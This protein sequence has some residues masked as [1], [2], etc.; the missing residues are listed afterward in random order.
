MAWACIHVVAVCASEDVYIYVPQHC[1]SALLCQD[2]KK[3]NN[4]KQ[5]CH[6]GCY[7]CG[8]FHCRL[9]DHTAHGLIKILAIKP[10]KRIY[11]I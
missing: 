1:V 7:H 5:L 8:C 9:A 2:K 6:S 3:K 11:W 4:K 10:G